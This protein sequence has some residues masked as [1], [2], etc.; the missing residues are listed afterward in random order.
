MARPIFLGNSPYIVDYF[1]K[2][3][4]QLFDETGGN[5]GNLAFLYAVASQLRP[6][7]RIMSWRATPE[8]FRQAGD[9]I[10]LP[11]ANQLGRHTDLGSSADLL[12]A[13]D[14]PVIGIGL[15]AQAENDQTDVEL[16]PGTERWLGTL[17]DL[18]PSGKPG[19]GLRGAYTAKQIQ[20]LYPDARVL[21]TGCP[22]NFINPRPGLGE[23]LQAR[24]RQR[25]RRVAVTAGIPYLPKLQWIEQRLA[26]MVTETD[27]AYIVQHGLEMIRLARSEFD[28]LG[29]DLLD[30]C[31]RYIMPDIDMEAFK[32]W[33]RAHAIGFYDTRGWL[34]FLRQFDFVVGTR[35]HGTMLALQAGVPAGCIAHD[36]RT[37]EMCRT[38]G[39]PVISADDF[40]Q[41]LEP[42]DL[43]AL[44][45]FNA[46]DFS[47]TRHDLAQAYGT[48]MH[49][50]GIELA[51]MIAE[52]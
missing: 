33:C 16:S 6:A 25:I 14:L 8:Q 43:T 37:M 27:G 13:I 31:R 15:G 22:S 19:L 45:G 49:G 23:V 10:V 48:L 28:E 44:F 35:F 50:A 39:V 36:S 1:V 26:R 2:S 11:L 21:I 20:R 47:S 40:P 3:A 51:P 46:A 52:L 18:A 32:T 12:R 9:V 5:T 30:T 7:P 34:D 41:H 38:M 24:Y 42:D 17:L 4:K 29:M